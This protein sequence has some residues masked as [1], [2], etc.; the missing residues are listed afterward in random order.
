MKK[1][2]FLL[3]LTGIF[4]TEKVN[5]ETPQSCSY[6][7]Q[8]T[9]AKPVASA[10]QR[11]LE[12]GYDVKFHH[13]NVNVERTTTAISGSVR[14][15]ATVISTTLD[16]FAFELYQTLTI[17]SIVYQGQLL[18]Y[19]RNNGDVRAKLP[20]TLNQGATVDL[21]IFYR[22]TPPSLPSALDDGFNND[23][24][25][26]WGN[27]ATW[28]LSQPYGAYHW[29]PCKQALQD[30]IDS[31]WV[32]ITT[33]STN[34]AGSNGVLE[35]VVPVG[36]KK[37]FEWK[38]HH[39]ID[40]YLIS[41]AVAQYV[42]K[43]N[44]A[45]LDNG[46]S[47]FIQNFIYN[48][49]ATYNRFKGQIDSIPFILELLDRL[50]GP[51]PFADEKYG[52]CMAPLSGG[53]EHQTMTTQGFFEMTLTAHEMGHQWFGDHVTCASWKDIFVN[54]GMA[55]YTEYLALQY[56]QSYNEAQQHMLAAH[57]SIMSQ[58]N[59]SIWFT[60]T[61]NNRIFDSRLS[62]DKGGA[63]VH[64]IRF[65]LQNDSI[66]FQF[67]RNYQ[68]KFAHST[69]SAQDYK[70]VLE[71]TSGRDFTQFFSQWFYGEGYPT[72]SVKYHFANGNLMLRV[73]ESV[74]AAASTP[75]FETPVEYLVKRTGAAD[76][77]IRLQQTANVNTFSVP[78]SGT[79]ITSITVDPKNWIINK[80]GTIAE[81]TSLVVLGI[82]S[83]QELL[84]IY[85]N[86]ANAIIHLPITH[87]GGTFS[88]MNSLGAVV[89]ATPMKK[90]ISIADVP[91]GLYTVLLQWDGHIQQQKLLICH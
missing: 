50:Y 83:L 3:A 41:V 72:F 20:A 43:N 21:T 7:K 36:N 71:A 61:S 79:A 5:A 16:S 90:E 55:T 22:G 67:L 25:P 19:T 74:S 82:S 58:T 35:R 4:S 27:Q 86:P 1:L 15:V 54:E 56:L 6:L 46:D 62:Y 48:N 8:F 53:M 78:M 14:T 9:G 12:E 24:S 26:S 57:T 51:Y 87:D 68:Q 30:K 59:G 80:T 37:R 66:F 60:D 23:F 44:Y 73:N 38:S 17:D 11:A 65:E 32:F 29:W 52:H 91:S 89:L 33:D 2:L 34:L 45:H 88:L 40:Y 84:P 64:M 70:T 10:A 28:S 69:A 63:M 39:P 13:L 85:P 77:T 75:L 81:D 18:G 76:T 47:V 31:S 42:Q 49:P